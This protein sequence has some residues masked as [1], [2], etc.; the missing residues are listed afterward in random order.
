[1]FSGA[2]SDS[3]GNAVAGA[4]VTVA[5][6]QE[7]I[8]RVAITDSGGA[9]RIAALPPAVYSLEVEAAGFHPASRNE[10]S[11]QVGASLTLNIELQRA[12]TPVF[13]VTVNSETPLIETERVQQSSVIQTVRI[14]NLPIDRRNYLDFT[15]LTPTAVSTVTMADDVDF[16]TPQSPQS[17][18]S[19][20]GNNGR[21]NMFTVDGIENYY[22]TGGVR[23]SLSQDAVQEFQVTRSNFSAEFGG[24]TGGVINVVSRTGTDDFHGTLFG[25]VRDRAFDARNYFDPTNS[26]FTRAQDGASAG[27][28]IR[29]GHLFWFGAYERLDRHETVFVPILS[30]RSA[31]AAPTASQQQFTTFLQ[32][33]GSPQLAALGSAL[34]NLLTPNNFPGTVR[35]FND[36]SGAFPFSEAQNQGSLR[37]DWRKGRQ[38]FFLRAML[39][40]DDAE[41][42]SSGALVGLN[43]SYSA[44]VFDAGLAAGATLVLSPQWL[45]ETRLSYG[46][47]DYNVQPVDPYGPQIDI[48]GYGF[49]GRPIYL[50]S[51]NIERHYEA[52]EILCW[53]TGRHAVKFG[54]E[55]NPVRDAVVQN[56][57]QTGLF[58]FG[59]DVP[60]S[61]LVDGLAGQPGFS[62]A[63]VDSFGA[64]V[65][66]LAA[67]LSDPLTSLQSYDLGLP[68]YYLQ[69]FGDPRWTGWTKRYNFFLQDE[70]SL[71]SRLHLY[72]G[73][74]YELE[75][76]NRL[77]P[78]DPNNIAPRVG[79]AWDPFGDAKMVVRAGYG[80]YYG[81]IDSNLNYSAQVFAGNQLTVMLVPLSGL[82]GSV[83]PLTGA[84]VTSADI[85]QYLNATG[86]L[87]NSAPTAADLAPLGIVVSPGAPLTTRYGVDP[88]F[89]NPYAQQASV[90]IER[91]FGAWAVSLGYQ[92]TR[93]VHLESSRD[94][95]LYLAGYT[96]AGQPIIGFINPLLLQYNV[97][98]STGNSWYNAMIAQVSRRLRS[99][100]TLN[101]SYTLSRAIDDVTD[102][103]P[104]FEANNQLDARAD[105]GLSP[106][107]QKHRFVGN[108]VYFSPWHASRGAGFAH[109]LFSD[110][111][112]SPIVIANSAVPFNLLTGYDNVGDRHVTTHR[113]PG[114]GRDI[115]IGPNFFTAN[116][117]L[118]RSFRWGPERTIE[119]IADGFNL[120]NRTNFLTV[121]NIVGNLT[122]AQLPNPLQARPGPPTSPLSYTSAGDPRQFQFGLRLRF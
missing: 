105:R 116:L 120:T 12:E 65:P 80:I 112:V 13:R 115:G 54:A 122:L 113:P 42:V 97:W 68:T 90:E 17:G 93:G 45:S 85:Y 61:S 69:G 99:N 95:N 82:P 32:N 9:Y 14:D 11:L 91:A 74:R 83:N 36:N 22:N 5:A 15:L 81:R 92:Y 50:P 75:L 53:T 29:K 20:G 62:A 48:T 3:A 10:I 28:P 104:D 23:P 77:F 88:H 37:L 63:L 118:S 70:F 34:N 18:I 111:V 110:F 24:S 117:R 119:F 43:R 73:A 60:L 21:G 26:A 7:G 89:V 16:R 52:D 2:V 86:V 66:G 8:S 1:M 47:D 67:Q 38:L 107:N 103:Q 4:R 121:N 27:G 55:I 84:P 6:Q 58:S 59:E 64:S 40:S 98:Q 57:P 33:S 35:L 51:K 19:F 106:F 31:F 102:F 72:L 71:T 25:F 108:A 46:F 41:H 30:D 101:A 87:G 44:G 79:L 56:L 94:Q 78:L 100:F 96:P 39:T 109:N 49:F 114:A 76:K